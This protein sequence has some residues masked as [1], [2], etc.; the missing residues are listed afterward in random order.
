MDTLRG[1]LSEAAYIE[2]LGNDHLKREEIINTL[3]LDPLFV[4]SG[5]PDER[6]QMVHLRTSGIPGE[7]RLI[8][9][10]QDS[11]SGDN[12]DICNPPLWTVHPPLR[13]Q[14]QDPNDPIIMIE[15]PIT[16]NIFPV[17]TEGKKF[18][19]SGFTID[20]NP[21]GI[22]A[23]QIA[24]I[25]AASGLEFDDAKNALVSAKD[26]PIG[27]FPII[28]S[29]EIKVWRPQRGDNI[30]V[31][32]NNVD[33]MRND[34]SQ[35]F[36]IAD[37]FIYNGRTENANK[38]FI[39]HA[40]K[41]DRDIF[42]TFRLTANSGRPVI[43][44][45]FPYRDMMVHDTNQDLN[46]IMRVSSVIDLDESSIKISDKTTG[47]TNEARGFS[48]DVVF[49]NGEYKRTITSQAFAENDIREGARLTYRFEAADLTGN[50]QIVERNVIMSNRPA[51]V[52]VTSS[53]APGNYGIN[54]ELL[55][56]V[57]FSLPVRVDKQGGTGPRL[58]LYFN[59]PGTG[60]PAAD[61]YADYVDSPAG[62]TIVFTYRVREGDDSPKLYTSYRPIE[63][64]GSTIVTTE[65]D[66]GDA[67][68]EFGGPGSGLQD[69]V[70][71]MVD[72][73]RPKITKAGFSLPNNGAGEFYYNIG[74]TVT[75]ELYTSEQV[76]ISG[77]PMARIGYN[78]STGLQ[79]V[80]ASFSKVDHNEAGGETSSTLFFTWMIDD[81]DVPETQLSWTSPWF[82]FGASDSITDMAGNGIDIRTSTMDLLTPDDLNGANINKTA[83]IITRPPAPPVFTLYRSLT[84]NGENILAGDTVA[85]NS[86]IYM[87]MDRNGEANTTIMYYSLE[88]GNNGQV[89]NTGSHRSIEDKNAAHK[90]SIL[91]IPS[92]YI[93]TGWQIDRAGNRSNN[94]AER[95]VI[96]NSR[97]PELVDITCTDPDGE[98]TAG[99]TLSFRLVF[100]RKVI[101][102]NTGAT[103][104]L[105]GTVGGYADSMTIP[106]TV[107]SEPVADTALVFSQEIPENMRMKDIK[108]TRIVLTGVKDAEYGN[109]LKEY[110][111]TISEE[112]NVRRP[113]PTTAPN[114]NRPGLIIDSIGPRIEQYNPGTSTG[115]ALGTGQYSNGGVMQNVTISSDGLIRNARITLTF[116]KD[117][118]AQS[119]GTITIKPWGDWAIPPIL[120]VEEMDA[121]YHSPL[122]GDNKIEYQRI[123]KWIDA[124]G[125]PERFD[126]N[127]TTAFGLRTRYNSYINTTHGL[128]QNSGGVG[129][130]RPDTRPKWVLAFDRDLY[131]NMEYLRDVF[132]AAEW[133][134]QTISAA[135]GSVQINPADRREVTITLPEP[136]QK[137]RI[138]EVTIS[139]GAFRDR[140]GNP[141]QPIVE[142]TRTGLH[143]RFWSPGTAD[144]V[145]RVD[146]YSH[147]DNYHGLPASYRGD[148][149][150]IPYI[151]TKV[152][153]D[154][155]T[156]GATIHYDTIRTKYTLAPDGSTANTSNAFTTTVNTATGFFNHDNFP[157]GSGYTN[158]T[159][160]DARALADNYL[161]NLLI[162]MN[163]ETNNA[164]IPVTAQN[165]A[166]LWTDLT[167]KGNGLVNDT[168]LTTNGR[169]YI[170]ISSNGTASLTAGTPVFEV[171]TLTAPETARGRFFYVGDA[172]RVNNDN[173]TENDRNA[174]TNTNAALFT[175]RRDYVTAAARKNA[176]T[177]GTI[178]GPDLDVSFPSYEGVFKTT[179]LHREPANGAYWLLI[180]GF[181][182]PV[183]PSTP[184]FP[185][186]EYVATP[187]SPYNKLEHTYFSK[188]AYR[189]GALPSSDP[190][191]IWPDATNVSNNVLRYGTNTPGV[192]LPPRVDNHIWV[193]WDIVS[194]WY[195]KGRNRGVNFESSDTEP[196]GN[197]QYHR[198]QRGDA[199]YGAVLATYGAVI[200]RYRQ[201]FH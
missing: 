68:I 10:V 200:Y 193:T 38:L 126:S 80:N 156:P 113:L 150:T 8:A 44:V 145:I 50:S 92:E 177:T 112:D 170:T 29:N 94:A 122:F 12:L 83:Y 88:A 95:S 96:I 87:T 188:Q 121:L 137:G 56:E 129:T 107:A 109:D 52:Y 82:V 37:D 75:L 196:G 86:E 90:N 101:A 191:G 36:H 47:N 133:K 117:V 99:R 120:T 124:N 13:I 155:E 46:L 197:I 135:S 58:K 184:G 30:L 176:V 76:R 53:N 103:L 187:P 192:P 97:A 164:I 5:S 149:S 55:F 23:I 157:F 18:S 151:D 153:I 42:K 146:R 85:V 15:N 28:Q 11:K 148:W 143:Y 70:A 67:I 186:Q 77:T 49:E 173:G 1:S 127:L 78:T 89:I 147:G 4:P 31:T 195:M 180:Q 22:E 136:L 3:A 6:S 57:V 20:L 51:V 166:I 32:L 40:Y 84:F 105:E 152:R 19:I 119:G 71:I 174:G 144:P 179:V 160:G 118:W 41:G 108:A 139:D 100:S 25:P 24:W 185:L 73:I 74:K 26:E 111:S 98:Y 123:L 63:L 45:I 115:T 168:T 39:I 33:Y 181:D 17:L 162:P 189:T 132:N 65:A 21:S 48:S 69:R 172:Y 182:T 171:I 61:A 81:D 134:W 131:D 128:R 54:R 102:E 194:D 169:V 62:N 178:A 161:R 167:T 59:D 106:L 34:F 201:D 64:N 27:N 125:I 138:W 198:L 159:I 140:A 116:D 35:E 60:E 114:L 199:N 141:S 110:T 93:I 72:G 79:I 154:C 104:T 130:A 175:G 190:A 14:V 91:Y 142:S 66:G 43:E 2:L 158:N 183:T 16:E 9:M 163:D 7:Y 165:G